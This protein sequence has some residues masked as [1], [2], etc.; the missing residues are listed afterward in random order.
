MFVLS[1]SLVSLVFHYAKSRSEKGFKAKICNFGE[2][3]ALLCAQNIRVLSGGRMVWNNQLDKTQIMRSLI[4]CA[5][6]Y[7][8]SCKSNGIQKRKFKWDNVMTRLVFLDYVG[9]IEGS[10]I[11]FIHSC[12]KPHPLILLFKKF[13]FMGGN[14]QRSL[15]VPQIISIGWFNYH[16]HVPLT[17]S[18][19]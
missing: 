17:S 1:G 14:F 2:Y 6:D 19:K 4:Y 18:G 3:E 13:W 9:F 5:Q 15:H 16:E 8:H 10:K 11:I 7:R 12:I